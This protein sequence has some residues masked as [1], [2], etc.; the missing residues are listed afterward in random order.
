MALEKKL[1]PATR[2]SYGKALA[3]LGKTHSNIVVLDGDLSK[4]TKT[5]SF[6][7]AFPERFFNVGIAEANMAGMAAGLASSG[8]IPFISSFACF[9]M[10]K[11]YDQLRMA[12]AFPELNVKVVASHGGISVGEDGA[13]QQSIEDFALAL[14]L[15]NFVVVVPADDVSARALVPQMAD[16]PGP[17][18]MRTGRPKAPIIYPEGSKVT[19]GKGNL[20][21]EGKDLTIFAVGLLVFEALAAADELHKKGI[22][23]AVCDLHTIKPIDRD[24]IKE[25]AQKTGA[26][27][28]CEEHQIYGG[29]GSVVARVISEEAPVPMEFVAIRDTYAE[30]GDPN[31]LMDRYGLTAPNIVMACQ[32]VLKRKK[33]S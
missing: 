3:E 6:A 7:K 32:R 31:Q 21:R 28:T 10:C 14:T 17:A 19:L 30:S 20:L 13:S 12:V 1:G 16:H 33:K 29:L 18:Y 25:Q 26:A 5:D 22:E 9:I 2:D 8:K 15:P 11:A 24:L 23:A 4:S 27:V